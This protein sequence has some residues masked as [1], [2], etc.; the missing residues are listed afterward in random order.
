MGPELRI[1][2]TPPTF[3]TLVS[4]A[5]VLWP[6][7]QKVPM[8]KRNMDCEPERCAALRFREAGAA[9]SSARL[10]R[11]PKSLGASSTRF[12]FPHPICGDDGTGKNQY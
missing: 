8:P 7:L 11:L 2:A 1:T 3:L 12:A 4:A 6:G 5:R 10:R 9:K